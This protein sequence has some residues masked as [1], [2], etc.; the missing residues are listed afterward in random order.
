MRKSA[1]ASIVSIREGSAACIRKE[2][3]AAQQGGLARASCSE[4]ENEQEKAVCFR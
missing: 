4:Q 3:L 1:V 2:I